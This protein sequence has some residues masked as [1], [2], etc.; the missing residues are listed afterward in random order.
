M[1]VNHNK[2]WE[3]NHA[4]QPSIPPTQPPLGQPWSPPA[5]PNPPTGP[6]KPPT[7]THNYDTRFKKR[8]GV[9]PSN[10][11]RTMTNGPVNKTTG[12]LYATRSQ[13][14]P[15]RIRT[16]KGGKKRKSGKKTRRNR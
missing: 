5:G 6:P 11:G 2:T 4:A 9:P 8:G 3:W 7:Y 10:R 12:S 1:A 13:S 14:A 16:K 15:P